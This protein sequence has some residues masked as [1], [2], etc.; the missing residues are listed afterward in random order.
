MNVNEDTRVAGRVGAREVDSGG[1]GVAAAGDLELVASHVWLGATG[2][3]SGVQSD[4]LRSEEVVAGGDVG[5]DLD[6]D[7][8]AALVQVLDAPE[9][10]VATPAGGVLL[11]GVLVDLE[12]AG[13]A[14]R[15]GRVADLGQVD[16]DGAVVVAAN[17]VSAAVTVARLL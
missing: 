15:G 5:G 14:V 11:P 2:A 17:T 10:V 7:T 12:P 8:A 13:R 1:G 9:V 3:A 6:V 16:H 4:N